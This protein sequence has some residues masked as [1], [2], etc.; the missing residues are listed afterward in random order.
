VVTARNSD[1]VWNETGASLAVAFQPFFYQTWWFYLSSGAV[2]ATVLFAA[3]KVRVHQFQARERELASLVEQQTEELRLV[4][5]ELQYLALADGLTGVANKRRFQE[6]LA[7]EWRRANRSQDS[8]ALLLLDIDHF[9][10][11]NDRY[12]HQAGDE[13][14][15]RIAAALTATASRPTDL[16]ARFGGE[17]FAIVLGG[18][19]L[20]GA[21]SIAREAG[22]IVQGL[23]LPHAGSTTSE[24]VT[25]SI[26]VAAAVVNDTTSSSDL[27][28]AADAALYRAKAE[29]RNR[30]QS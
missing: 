21:V 29:G 22:A 25:I 18:T 16:L 10:P 7:A 4:N 17:E 30:V 2:A 12:G 27:I 14:L 26:G 28:G 11:Y 24:F 9:K 5:E 13:C 23:R 1:D 3:W 15:A 8:I 6:F 20:N 19:D